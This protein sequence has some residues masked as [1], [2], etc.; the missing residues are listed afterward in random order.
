MSEKSEIVIRPRAFIVGVIS[1][2]LVT[3]FIGFVALFTPGGGLW[4]LSSEAWT[5]AWVGRV[6]FIFFLPLIVS[7]IGA[8]ASRSSGGL[9]KAELTIVMVMIWASWMLPTYYG[10]LPAITMLGTAR[11]IPA[12]HRWNLEY[13]RDVNW[14]WGP[15]PLND[16]LW[17]SWMYGGPVPWAEWM[18]ALLLHTARLIPYYLMFVFLAT[19]FRRQW[20]DI[21]AL[22]FPQ[23][24]ATVRLIDMAYEKVDSS[25]RLLR[26]VWLWLG[27][28]V[29]FIA[30][31]PYWGWTIP[32]LGLT[33]PR[34]YCNLGIDLTP[35]VL[36]PNALLNFN[37]EAF[38]IG[39]ALLVP[40][41]TLFSFIVSAIVVYW[42]WWPMMH[43]LG[44]WESHAAGAFGGP[45]GLFD[46]LWYSWTGPMMKHWVHTWGSPSWLGFGTGFGL[47]F[48]PILVVFRHEL[49][50]TFKA[51]IRRAP[52]EVEAREPARYTTLFIAYIVCLLVYVATWWYSS[53]G[54][55][56]ILFGVIWC[57][58]LGLFLMGKAKIA[59]EYGIVMNHIE[60]G[61]WAHIWDVSMRE[62]WIADPLS[63]FFIG[64][65]KSRF[66][67]L[68]SDYPW[69]YTFIGFTPQATT[70]EAY[71]MGMLEGVHSR[72]ILLAVIIATMVGVP[73]SLFTLLP[74][75]CSFGVLRLSA[76]NYTGAPNN[77]QQ[78]G[79]TYACITATGD[80]WRGGFIVAPVATQWIQFAVGFAIV[81][82][83]Y[84]LHTR[85]PWFPINPGGVAM[86][87][88]WLP[89]AVLVP[90]I[91]AYVAKMIVLR[92]G[93][94]KLYEER[95]MPFAIGLASPTGIAVLLGVA[96]NLAATLAA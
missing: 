71:R 55:L 46:T 43:Y 58:L 94:T 63:P 76:F 22:P 70:L 2:V 53:G 4:G 10:V 24:M 93:G 73:T 47:I 54:N 29:G 40:V 42:I 11:Q 72:Y 84:A 5:N 1:V 18:P 48:Y 3:V 16:K 62:W 31:F 91:V 41:K 12:F 26:S 45:E 35:L 36:I 61:P 69:F 14:M 23:A 81:S 44:F 27:V 19:L 75:W 13:A 21:E 25:S 17:E 20:L 60:D 66:L 96:S 77:Y 7:L 56:P 59:G 95:V 67:V 87:F 82:V 28:L 88:G 38:F 52:P 30:I 92:I 34:W 86:G 9:S 65:L 15:D 89:S 90:S 85:Y 57:V 79:P 32:G 83:I 80:Y 39:F 33:K 6:S 51:L 74:M 78:R 68:R 50:N 37:F 8:L 64:D 49:A